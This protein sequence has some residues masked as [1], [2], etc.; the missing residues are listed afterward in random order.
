VI[1]R[2]TWCRDIKS[3][4]LGV[5]GRLARHWLIVVPAPV[6]AEQWVF[7][8]ALRRNLSNFRACG[9]IVLRSIAGAA[10]AAFRPEKDQRRSKASISAHACEGD[11]EQHQEDMMALRSYKSICG[12]LAAVAVVGS[13]AAASAQVR[14]DFP[15]AKQPEAQVRPD[16]PGAKQA[17]PAVRPDFPGAKQGDPGTKSDSP[18]AKPG[19]ATT[20]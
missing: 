18:N 7:F 13:I 3:A 16:F 8:R 12:A 4:A 14:P 10:S 17:D 9:L 11:G 6:D 5:A 2:G 1:A 20:K 19:D 15:G